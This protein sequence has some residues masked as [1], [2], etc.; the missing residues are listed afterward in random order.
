MKWYDSYCMKQ[1]MNDTIEESIKH[2]REWAKEENYS[3][4]MTEKV[5]VSLRLMMSALR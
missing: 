2:L 4:E 1:P 5:I 3:V